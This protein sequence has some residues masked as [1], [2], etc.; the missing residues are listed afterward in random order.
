MF[1][2]GINQFGC[3]F[4]SIDR[5][6]IVCNRI[7]S[8]VNMLVRLGAYFTDVD[9]QSLRKGGVSTT[10]LLARTYVLLPDGRAVPIPEVEDRGSAWK[11]GL[12]GQL[13]MLGTWNDLS[14]MGTSSALLF[15]HSF[16]TCGRAIWQLE[17][18]RRGLVVISKMSNS[19]P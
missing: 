17:N 11:T 5:L 8:T 16:C 3:V 1:V 7:P 10:R 15:S 12:V 2:T 13:H 9:R 18:R 14:R 4:L 19:T 6:S